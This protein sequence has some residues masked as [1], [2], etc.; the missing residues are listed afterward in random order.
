MN[1][2]IQ[3][4]LTT[5]CLQTGKITYFQTG[6]GIVSTQHAD[7]FAIHDRE[8]FLRA[9]LASADQPALMPPV[10]IPPGANPPRQ[11]VDGG[12][13]EVA[14]IR[15][16]IDNGATDVYVIVLSPEHGQTKDKRFQG[17]P[18][19]L[20]RTIGLFVE[21]VAA[22]DVGTARLYNDSIR[23]LAAVRDKAGAVHGLSEGE[24]DDL[25]APPGFP[26]P[27]A[28]KRTV[29]L[30]IVRPVDPLPTDGLD[31][32]PAVMT[33]MMDLGRQRAR[34]LLGNVPAPVVG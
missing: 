6:P 15:I 12:V 24:L 31:F 9:V 7:V 14:P 1:S 22:N 4:V 34:Q 10:V 26:N 23:Y 11:Y 25:F 21:D 13:K 28:G 5:V 32:D 20:M 18:D 2:S 16:A 33:A 19:I 30:H 3:M 27:F 8:T 17:L 29:N